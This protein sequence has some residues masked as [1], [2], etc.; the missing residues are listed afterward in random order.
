MPPHIEWHSR[1]PPGEPPSDGG[2][3][4]RLLETV[5]ETGIGQAVC[6]AQIILQDMVFEALDLG[7]DA[8]LRFE[9]IVA[10]RKPPWETFDNT[11][12]TAL[13][14]I[15]ADRLFDLYCG[16]QADNGAGD[17]VGYVTLL[18][19]EVP[20]LD[21]VVQD[22]AGAD[23]Y[24]YEVVEVESFTPGLWNEPFKEL[25][26]LLRQAAAKARRERNG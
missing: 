9:D 20:Q 13:R 25:A 8:P 3:R 17:N 16:M 24:R 10:S 14:W 19:D 11:D 26:D 1:E 4:E 15:W 21:M 22:T 7:R 6:D 12:C 2:R 23:D 18:V 5:T